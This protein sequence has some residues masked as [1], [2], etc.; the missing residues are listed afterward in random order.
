MSTALHGFSLGTL[1]GTEPQ[2]VFIARTYTVCILN[3]FLKI[4]SFTMNLTQLHMLIWKKYFNALRCNEFVKY[5]LSYETS[6]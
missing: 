1:H 6:T 3:E 4:S 2:R 5:L